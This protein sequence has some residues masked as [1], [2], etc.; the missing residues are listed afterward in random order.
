MS[1]DTF[2]TPVASVCPVCEQVVWSDGYGIPPYLTHEGQ[3]Y[4]TACA[5]E[6]CTHEREYVADWNSIEGNDSVEYRYVCRDC[7]ATRTEE[8]IGAQLRAEGEQDD[9]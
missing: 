4:H 8:L 5:P 7:G 6:F 3:R 2:T 9:A 1:F